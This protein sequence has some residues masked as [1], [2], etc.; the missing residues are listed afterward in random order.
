MD[1]PPTA[2]K[3]RNEGEQAQKRIHTEGPENVEALRHDR[4]TTATLCWTC[5]EIRGRTVDKVHVTPER[6]QQKTGKQRQYKKHVSKLLEEKGLNTTMMINKKAWA[7]KLNRI[8]PRDGTD[9]E[10]NKIEIQA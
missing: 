9:R 6:P 10:Q 1:A 2:D 7:E 5:L 4:R 3:G 8:Y